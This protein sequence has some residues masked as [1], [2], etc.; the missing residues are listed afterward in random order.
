VLAQ[1]V[2]SK[3]FIVCMRKV[4][5]LT[6]EIL[7][8]ALR[9]AEKHSQHFIIAAIDGIIKKI[10]E[11]IPDSSR[12]A[13]FEEKEV[14]GDDYL[15]SIGFK[16]LLEVGKFVTRANRGKEAELYQQYALC[17]KLLQSIVNT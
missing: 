12:Y 15:E 4:Y 11:T 9:G 5:N 8:Q 7:N 13:A 10:L 3:V 6:L 17:G 16:G 1:V 14:I 2:E